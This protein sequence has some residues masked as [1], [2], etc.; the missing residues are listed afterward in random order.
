MPGALRLLR[1]GKAERQALRLRQAAALMRA[2]LHA[3]AARACGAAVRLARGDAARTP[4]MALQAL[5]LVHAG[6]FRLALAVAERAASRAAAAGD[7]GALA[8]A[9][10]AAGIG[11]GRLGREREAIPLL[12]EAR[13]LFRG[14]G[15]ARGEADVLQTLAA[16]RARL[17]EEQA[18]ADF[19]EAIALDR[20]QGNEEKDLKARLGLAVLL[21]RCGRYEEAVAGL[22]EVR[23]D[24]AAQ[25]KVGVQE[26]ALSKL[27]VAALDQGRLHAAILLAGQAADLALYLADHNLI[28]VN[29]CAL[30]DAWIRCGRAGRAVASLRETLEMPLSQV[31]PENVDYA[32]MLLANAWMEAGGADEDHLR[33][34]LE[35]TLA[36]CRERRKR[37]SWLMAL[38]IEMERRAAAEGADPFQPIGHRVPDG[39]RGQPRLPGRGDPHPRG[40]GCLRIPSQVLGP[41]GGADA[42]GG[43]GRARAWLPG[44]RGA[45][46]GAPRP[47]PGARGPRGGG[48]RRP[49]GRQASPGARP[50]PGS[51]TR[52]CAHDFLERPVYAALRRRD[53]QDVRRSHSRLSTLYDMIRALNSEPDPEGLLETILDLALRAVSA[54]RGWSSCGRTGRGRV[55]GNSRCT[56]PATWR[57]RRSTMPSRTAAGSWRRPARAAPSW[58]STPAPT[59]A[60]ATWPA[61][62]CSASA[63]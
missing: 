9:R 60:S 18:E 7:A 28:L 36:R 42:R 51:R 19:L 12:E 40:A 47:G 62:A 5:A 30:A 32:R 49:G 38:V 27:A 21:V 50:P 11:L 54:E 35:E 61:S 59:C 24:A 17:G 63:P 33:A 13:R 57:R 4:A 56:S 44:V 41:R 46:T 48:R 22:E 58:R 23:A 53:S 26:I 45:G 29:R 2:G 3:A 43:G 55:R 1:R 52:R 8:L 25:G 16:C 10:R 37:R 15:D 6:R 20:Q 31:E 39:S 14:Q 34:L